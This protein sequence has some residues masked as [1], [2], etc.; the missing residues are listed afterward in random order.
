MKIA[1]KNHL[2][3]RKMVQQKISRISFSEAPPPSG[4][5]KAVRV[6]LGLSIRQ[7]ADRVGVM[8]GSIDQIEKREAQKKVT[9]E[10]IEQLASAMECK[11]IYAIVPKEENATLDSIVE[12]KAQELAARILKSVSHS[13][14]LEAQGTPDTVV[15]AEVL[16]IAKELKES[17][18]FRI[19]ENTSKKK[20]KKSNE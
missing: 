14:N 12:Q 2:N 9:L 16:R 3:Q 10:S 15:N 1:S 5:L 8:H 13:M 4:W 18:D 6:A 17:G 7:L 11:L 20:R 19:W